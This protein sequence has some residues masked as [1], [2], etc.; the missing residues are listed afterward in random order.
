MNHVV[1]YTAGTLPILKAPAFSW[2]NEQA[3]I[4]YGTPL[5]VDQMNPSASAPGTFLFTPP[6]GTILA[7]GTQ[8]VTVEF[9]PA[10]TD[11]YLGATATVVFNVLPPDKVGVFNWV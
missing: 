6:L 5:S 10:D 4:T 1:S 11:N 8:M 9:I 3:T 7:E 2:V